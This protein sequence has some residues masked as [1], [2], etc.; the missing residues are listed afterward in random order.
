MGNAANSL[1]PVAG[2][3]FNLALRDVAALV[4]LLASAHDNSAFDPGAQDALRRYVQWRQR[5]QQT[6]AWFTHGLVKLFTHPARSVS[7]A[8]NLG[9][10]AF[11]LLPGAKAQLARQA[12]GLA[13]RLPRLV[14]GG[15]LSR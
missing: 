11:D 1:H 3:G 8:R 5:D 9:L 12:M 15:G 14:R 10:V 6:A 4:D 13:G 2:Q 7:L